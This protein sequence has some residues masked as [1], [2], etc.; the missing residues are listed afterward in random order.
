MDEKLEKLIKPIKDI[1]VN[2]EK[3]VKI[4]NHLLNLEAIIKKDKF[5]ETHSLIHLLQILT[6]VKNEEKIQKI[7]ILIEKILQN[8][9]GNYS[10]NMYQ[11]YKF[12]NDI[13]V[14]NISLY[15]E[16]ICKNYL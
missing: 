12:L 3:D 11:F 16:S 7:L 8:T 13:K 4:D 10:N 9:N 15:F 6:K 14:C 1:C 2:I 5:F